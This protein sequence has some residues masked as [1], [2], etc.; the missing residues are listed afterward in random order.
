MQHYV[1][2]LLNSIHQAA[3]YVAPPHPIWYKSKADPDNELE[4]E[5][6]SYVEEFIYGKPRPVGDIT[7]IRAEELPPS[8]Q[9]TQD[10]QEELAKA[11]EDL[12]N[13]FNFCL[14]FPAGYPMIMRYPFIREFW[15]SE[16]VALS[17]GTNHIEF[18]DYD[19]TNCPFPGYCHGCE[20]VRAQMESDKKFDR[21]PEKSAEIDL[22]GL[23]PTKEEIEQW[24]KENH[25][26]EETAV[27]GVETNEDGWPN[28]AP[29]YHGIYDDE[30]NKVNTDLI[31]VPGLCLVCRK[32]YEE[33]ANEEL[34]CNLN[35]LDQ[36]NDASF[37]C[38]ALEKNG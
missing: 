24:F 30:G 34:L 19:E 1:D 18:C 6:L 13:H 32:Y 35:R 14:E 38:G 16:Q 37:E 21:S 12:L 15:L 36:N 27:D 5:D 4:L 31:P 22:K 17:F 9:L 20:E 29:Y 11:L 10:Q 8:E 7:G 28:D 23:L 2:Q 25:P 26:D 33:D 3:L